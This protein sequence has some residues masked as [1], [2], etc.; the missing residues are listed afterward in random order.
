MFKVAWKAGKKHYLVI[1]VCS[2]LFSNEPA[3]LLSARWGLPSPVAVHTSCLRVS[4]Q[5]ITILSK[6]I[7]NFNMNSARTLVIKYVVLIYIEKV[8]ETLFMFHIC[9]V[10][11][12][13]CSCE[14]HIQG[15]CPNTIKTFM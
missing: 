10:N 5:F 4:S 14:K 2:T 15:G 9:N 1:C 3:V 13:N 11:N 6:S 8:T 7:L 12:S